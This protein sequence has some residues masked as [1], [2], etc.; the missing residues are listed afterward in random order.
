MEKICVL[1]TGAGAPGAPGIIKSL[2]INGER[3]IV[4]VGVDVDDSFSSGMGMVD[5]FYKVPKPDNERVFVD[6]II[7]IAIKHKVQVIVP[8]V[9]KE[10]FIFSK[11]IRLFNEREI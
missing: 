5:F 7:T 3:E 4:I 1:I 10:L 11:N 9:T 2:R 8:L 6:A